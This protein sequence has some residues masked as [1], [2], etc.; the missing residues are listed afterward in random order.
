MIHNFR[1]KG[2]RKLHEENITKGV[3]AIYLPKIRRILAVLET[4]SS[5]DNMDAPGF[6]LHPLRGD[7][8]NMWSITVG[9][10]WRIVFRFEAPDV[11][12]VD[13]TDYH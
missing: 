5:L 7:L 2:L 3:E 6:R 12:D 9:A 11:Y 4:A 8:K 13:L 1:H 10:N